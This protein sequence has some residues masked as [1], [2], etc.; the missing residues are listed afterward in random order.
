MLK[1]LLPNAMAPIK[2]ADPKRPAMAISII[3]KSGTVM[4]VM[5]LGTASLKIFLSIAQKYDKNPKRRNAREQLFFCVL[6]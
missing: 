4:L 5:I 2:T 1:I 6:K 3:P